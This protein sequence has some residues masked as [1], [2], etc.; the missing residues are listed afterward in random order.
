[1]T[2]L[3]PGRV[4][5]PPR[6]LSKPSCPVG[7]SRLPFQSTIQTNRKRAMNPVEALNVLAGN[8]RGSNPL[9]DPNTGEPEES[10]STVTVTPVLDGRFVRL[11]YTWGDRGKPQEGSLLIGFDP[12]SGEASGHWIDTLHMGR[13]AMNCLG[14]TPDDG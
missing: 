12:Q 13:K 4:T 7:T 3:H 11:D 1:M 14:A 6:I 2:T 10:P 5:R 8:R 9:Q